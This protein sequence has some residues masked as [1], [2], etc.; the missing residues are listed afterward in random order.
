LREHYRKS[1]SAAIIL[2]NEL[3]NTSVNLHA[4]L[5]HLREQAGVEADLAIPKGIDPLE[6]LNLARQ[7]IGAQAGNLLRGRME[8]ELINRA[9]DGEIAHLVGTCPIDWRK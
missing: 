4:A 5:L 3:A 9:T 1:W 2:E 8:P 6:L 7:T